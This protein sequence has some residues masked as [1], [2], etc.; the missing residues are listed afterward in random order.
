VEEKERGIP[1]FFPDVLILQVNFSLIRRI[2]E[3]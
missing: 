1:A 3:E 2:F